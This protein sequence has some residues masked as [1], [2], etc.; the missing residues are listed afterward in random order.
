MKA[1]GAD[2]SL[3]LQGDADLL[4]RGSEQFHL[5]I[6]VAGS[7]AGSTLV[8]TKDQWLI[9]CEGGRFCFLRLAWATFPICPK[10]GPRLIQATQAE[11]S[12][13]RLMK[14]DDGLKGRIA[15]LR[16]ADAGL[17]RRSVFGYSRGA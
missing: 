8:G 16:G 3:L 9:G 13:L 10:N 14:G 12:L 15:A 4:W 5:D 6:S 11:F 1:Q 2:R 17:K 7:S